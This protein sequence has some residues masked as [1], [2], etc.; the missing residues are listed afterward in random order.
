LSN[1]AVG[2][3]LKVLTFVPLALVI[4]FY[5]LPNFGVVLTEA[6]LPFFAL[7]LT[8]VVFGIVLKRRVLAELLNLSKGSFAWGLVTMLFGAGLYVFGSF[9]NT[10]TWIHFESLVVL[11]VGYLASRVGTRVLRATSPLLLILA[12]G[13]LP[14]QV[15]P[16]GM[17]LQVQLGV[18]AVYSLALLAYTKLQV[19]PLILGGVIVSIGV[20]A[21]GLSGVASRAVYPPAAAI[22]PMSLIPLVYPPARGFFSMKGSNGSTACPGHLQESDGFCSLC[23]MRTK[24]PA[25]EE[26]IGLWGLTAL[27]IIA[28]LLVLAS[29]PALTLVGGVPYDAVYTNRGISSTSVPITPNGWQVNSTKVLSYAV[30]LY[31]INKVYVPIVHPETKNYS[32]YYAIATDSPISGAPNGGEITGWNRSSNVFMTIGPLHGYLTTYTNSGGTMFS[33]LGTTTMFFLNGSNPGQQRLTSGYQQV[34][35]G[36]V[37]IFKNASPSQDVSQF[38]DDIETNWMP[39]INVDISYSSWSDFLWTALQGFSFFEPLIVLSASAGG[40]VLLAGSAVRRDTKL[41]RFLRLSSVLPEGEWICLSRILTWFRKGATGLQIGVGQDGTFDPGVIATLRSLEG[42][43]LIERRL[44]ENGSGMLLIW[45]P[46][47]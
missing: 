43:R 16:S 13:Y 7:S 45:R 44:L 5:D 11:F 4:F 23:G 14:L 34:S 21:W 19:R 9:S 27:G 36:F 6:Y 12:F 17:M 41:D 25:A 15:F 38:I 3:A 20:I 24:R 22:I 26:G 10:P 31:A 40:I 2:S 8:L 33:Y 39:G 28:L 46:T 42:R 30:D 35:I 18:L 37:R 29:F 1:S 47:A 32:V